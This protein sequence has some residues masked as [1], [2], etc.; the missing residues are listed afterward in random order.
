MA[1]FNP[2][3]VASINNLTTN[4][5]KKLTVLIHGGAGTITGNSNDKIQYL[6]ALRRII[7]EIYTYSSGNIYLLPPIAMLP[8]KLLT[9]SYY[10]NDIGSDL[11]SAVDVVEFAVKL[12]E[13]EPL[14]NAGRGAVF[15][16]NG[17]LV[18]VPYLT[19]R[20]QIIYCIE[21]TY[22]HFCIDMYIFAYIYVY[23]TYIHL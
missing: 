19:Y 10:N 5:R 8:L 18:A 13:D 23:N 11:I 7:S 16:E 14:F 2:A 4:M 6:D 9:D 1:F 3:L 22:V 15:N 17:L 20:I 21:S 12:L